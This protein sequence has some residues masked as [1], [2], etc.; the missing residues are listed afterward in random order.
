[1]ATS[2]AIP[3]EALK[4][5]ACD[6]DETLLTSSDKSISQP[7][8]E[9][10]VSLSQ[11]GVSVLLASGRHL[12]SMFSYY[13][14]LCQAGVTP[15]PIISCNGALVTIDDKVVVRDGLEVEVARILINFC[16]AQ[17][18]QLNYYLE[19]KVYSAINGDLEAEVR[20]LVI[21]LITEKSPDNPNNSNNTRKSYKPSECNL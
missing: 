18:V 3:L 19:E 1:M 16:E 20:I 10:L 5:V 14:Q 11:S 9:A 2:S 4:A 15:G 17:S 8:L 13:E 21:F 12:S 6:M 7:N